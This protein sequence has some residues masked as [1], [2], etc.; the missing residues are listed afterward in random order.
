MKITQKKSE[1]EGKKVIN[2]LTQESYLNYGE[3]LKEVTDKC[4]KYIRGKYSR[5]L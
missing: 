5:D 4:M 2:M 1:D 3:N